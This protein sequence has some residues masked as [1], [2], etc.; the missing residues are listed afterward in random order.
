MNAWMINELNCSYEDILGHISL[1]E[2]A[3]LNINSLW[4]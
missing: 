1:F 4:R 2:A 3:D